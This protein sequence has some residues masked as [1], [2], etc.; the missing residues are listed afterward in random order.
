MIQRQVCGVMQPLLGTA[1]A[2]TRGDPPGHTRCGGNLQDETAQEILGPLQ[3][4]D[5]Q[6]A[7]L[8]AVYLVV[9]SMSMIGG[10]S[11]PFNG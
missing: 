11:R 4:L 3:V 8:L 9:R 10:N 1:A 5:D 7:S 2:S 6:L